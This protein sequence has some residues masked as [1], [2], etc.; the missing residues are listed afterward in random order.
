MFKRIQKQKILPEK[1]H[2]GKR[3]E[4]TEINNEKKPSKTKKERVPLE[5]K[6]IN[7]CI[8]PINK[9]LNFPHRIP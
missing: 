9:G 3:A 1:R 5:S 2:K 6:Y 4:T 8:R 7:K